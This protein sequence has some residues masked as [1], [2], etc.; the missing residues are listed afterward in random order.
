VPW[1]R[2]QCKSSHFDFNPI[3]IDDIIYSAPTVPGSLNV[4]VN[5]VQEDIA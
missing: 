3:Y 1:V 4:D 2:L 5:Y